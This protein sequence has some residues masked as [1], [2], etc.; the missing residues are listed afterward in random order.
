MPAE[1]LPASHPRGV[2][3]K[4]TIGDIPVPSDMMAT[5]LLR[6]STYRL[7]AER[8]RT[9]GLAMAVVLQSGDLHQQLAVVDPCCND[10]GPAIVWAGDLDRDEKL[11]LL[12]SNLRRP[13]TPALSRAESPSGREFSA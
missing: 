12:G 11:D 4:S 8:S 10:A 13:L 5:V 3:Y 7:H 6:N 2:K 1:H 9:G